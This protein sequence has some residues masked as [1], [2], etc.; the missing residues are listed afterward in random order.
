[1]DIYAEKYQ[2]KKVLVI[3][4]DYDKKITGGQVYDHY[5]VSRMSA[6]KNL[7]ITVCEERAENHD[8]FF[9]LFSYLKLLKTAKNYD[10]IISNSRYYSKFLLLFFFLKNFYSKKIIL[11]HHHFSFLSES[12]LKQ[13]LHRWFEM[14]FLRQASQVVIPSPYIKK[15]MKELLP[16]KQ[17]VYIPLAFKTNNNIPQSTL[18]NGNSL[19]FVGT[20]E[21]RKGIIFLVQALHLLKKQSLSFF[22]SVVG[23]ITDE[24]YYQNLIQYIDENGLSE[25]IVF[26]GRVSD[27]ELNSLYTNS[28]CFVFPSL[29]EGFGMVLIEAM[30]HGLPVIA[31]DNSAIPYTVK[32][33]ENGLLVEDKSVEKFAEAIKKILENEELRIE[34][35]KNAHKTYLN[36]YSYTELN[37]DID[38][39]AEKQNG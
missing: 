26:R 2:M 18:K 28:D 9:A 13:K 4:P 29:H 11:F 7:S 38:T 16:K 35:G 20:I 10:I 33:N 31:F 8:S 21:P 39:F 12:G 22:C 3:Y 27:E 15:L 34:L 23:A 19:L 32:N 25:N 37:K 30:S 6:C 36:S 14:S 1:M 24:Y 17:A 5:F